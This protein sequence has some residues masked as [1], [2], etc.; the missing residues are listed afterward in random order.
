M[1]SYKI[2]LFVLVLMSVSC[3]KQLEE[4]P[5]GLINESFLATPDGLTNLVLS[6]YYQ[7]RL[8]VEDLRY[9][10]EYPSD[11]MTHSLNSVDVNDIAQLKVNTMP[12]LP[13]FSD[14][15]RHLY[16][17]INNLNFGIKAI[18]DNQLDLPTIE[19][20][21]S[22]L[23]AWFYLIVV[24]T[25]G[26][27]AHFTI[28]PTT[29]IVTEGNQTTIDAFYKVILGDIDNAISKLPTSAAEAG[30]I[31][32]GSAKAMKARVLLALA[33]YSED[34]IS[35][36]GLGSKAQIYTATKALCDDVINSYGYK[37]LANFEDIFSTYNQNNEEVIWA[38]QFSKSEKFNTS[39]LTTGGNGLH[40]YWVGNYNRSARTQ[41]IVPRMYGHSIFYGREY[42]H[43]MMTRYFL[44][45]F[46]QAEDS[47][48]DGTIQT[49]WLA[50]WNDA[51]K[52]EDA[53]G[54]PVKNG[55]PTDTVLYK[56]LFN[57][58]DAMAASYKARGIAIDG[59]N[60]IYQPDGTPIA[61]A[62]SW[63][64]TMKKHLDPSRFVPKDEASHKETIIL[65]LGDVYLMAAESALMSGSQAEAAL[66][67]DQLRARARKFPAA[68][69]VVA[70]EIDI[71]YIMDER[72]RE[73][74]GELQRWF[75]LKRT[76][77]MVSRI[78]AHN[79]DSKAIS[80]EHELR[81]VP[82][83]ELDKVTN[84]DAFKQNPGYPT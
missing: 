15:W 9:L 56:P 81:P 59:L 65:R 17:G 34:I 74:G 31:T 14:S 1:N 76:H 38:V 30:R 48:T 60:H 39:E 82:Q 37:L 25:W 67:I 28:E 53:F 62:R 68:L 18:K 49:A 61:A 36:S 71:N 26:T 84:R 32:S 47:R 20:E 78:K 52:V 27:G 16:A 10:G 75:D 29:G 64:H 46:N 35:K 8:V 69:P 5:K 54:V 77:T 80:I 2:F 45:M 43:H 73:L 79:P 19:G 70:S 13:A 22:F 33:G 40:R 51:L 11:I 83:S 23:R 3:K 55:A 41:E 42:R 57:V 44:T 66:Y 12:T 7:S 24:E 21:L 58:D 4:D 6:Q 63:Y 50:L 72:A